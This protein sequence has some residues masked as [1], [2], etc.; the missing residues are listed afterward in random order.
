MG[1]RGLCYEGVVGG[2][3]KE[4]SAVNF[5][6]LTEYILYIMIILVL[7]LNVESIKNHRYLDKN[8][9]SRFF[10]NSVH[11]F[12]SYL[13]EVG[14]YKRKQELGQESNQENKNST[15]KVNKKTK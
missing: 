3:P 9:K 10:I 2:V 4:N 15:K 8:G 5:V 1:R 13:A 6:Y 7:K 12:Y 14:I 11:A